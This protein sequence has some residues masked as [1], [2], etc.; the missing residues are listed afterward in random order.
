MAGGA[1]PQY[2]IGEVVLSAPDVDKDFLVQRMPAILKLAGGV[3]LYASKL[4]LPLTVSTWAWG[5]GTTRAGEIHAVLGPVVVK[6]MDTIDITA[7][8]SGFLGI[9]NH[10]LYLKPEIID[11][12]E[13][14]LRNSQRPPHDRT[15]RLIQQPNKG[16][17]P[18]WQYQ[19][20]AAPVAATAQ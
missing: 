7:L 15:R 20:P 17:E 1:R 4:D 3:T 18:Y 9:R 8:G 14:L 2:S 11:D 13:G 5:A 19:R 12:I 16:Q 10:N 6:G